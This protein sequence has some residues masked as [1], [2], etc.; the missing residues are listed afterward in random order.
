MNGKG[1]DRRPE[2]QRGNYAKGWD[3]LWGRKQRPYE[4]AC[5]LCGEPID[6]RWWALP[7][8]CPDCFAEGAQEDTDA[9]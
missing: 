5:L 3:A 7:E 1:S 8:A 6:T 2:A 9:E 4:V